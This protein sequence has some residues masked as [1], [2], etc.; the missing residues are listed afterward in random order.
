NSES[1]SLWEDRIA[2][3]PKQFEP[4]KSKQ[5]LL[6]FNTEKKEQTPLPGN[7]KSNSANDYETFVM[8]TIFYSSLMTT[9]ISS[10]RFKRTASMSDRAIHPSKKYANVS[11]ING[12][13][14]PFPIS[15]K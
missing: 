8:N 7:S 9:S 13:D 2:N 3:N 12:L 1:I 14:F 6:L 11:R 15:K 4:K 5:E 10:S